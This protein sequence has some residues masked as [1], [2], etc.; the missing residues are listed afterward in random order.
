MGVWYDG[1]IWWNGSFLSGGTTDALDDRFVSDVPCGSPPLNDSGFSVW[2]HARDSENDISLF[3]DF[4]ILDLLLN[5]LER[6]LCMETPIIVVGSKFSS[7]RATLVARMQ[8][9]VYFRDSSTFSDISTICF[10]RVT[11][12]ILAFSNILSSMLNVPIFAR[13]NRLSHS[14]WSKS[15]YSL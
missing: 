15:M 8:W 4:L 5:L 12:P 2:R 10:P 14:G 7:R 6:D 3:V 13:W 11:A 9:L 1:C